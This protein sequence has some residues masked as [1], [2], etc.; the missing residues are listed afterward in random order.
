MASYL[1]GES[2]FGTSARTYP[3]NEVRANRFRY[4]PAALASR[5][6]EM[7]ISLAINIT[8]SIRLAIYSD[9]VTQP[10]A[11]LGV[12]NE[13]VNPTAGV[14]TVSMTAP[15]D[16]VPGSYY[17]LCVN[18][19]SAI[20]SGIYGTTSTGTGL[21][22]TITYA[23]GYPDPWGAAGT[24]LTTQTAIAGWGDTVN[25]YPLNLNPVNPV[26][27]SS[28]DLT[29][30]PSY[31][32]DVDTQSLFVKFEVY[33]TGADLAYPSLE[34]LTAADQL[35]K[36]HPFSPEAPGALNLHRFIG[37]RLPTGTRKIR[38]RT[39]G[40]GNPVW[41]NIAASILLP[42]ETLGGEVK[43]GTFLTR[44]KLLRSAAHD[45]NATRL[46]KNTMK[47]GRSY[48]TIQVIEVDSGGESHFNNGFN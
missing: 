3:A 20:T 29:F 35:L 23:T 2:V 44:A 30:A 21:Y 17:W 15:V 14:K 46:L 36:S 42:T 28:Q 45:T 39:N 48:F 11:R 43:S 12:S 10:N 16:L 37:C 4:S 34:L 9:G 19:S 8:G 38:I 18:V 1:L 6:T 32:T 24:S 26:G 33:Q 31:N 47:R 41:S 7:R 40:S 27:I 25:A 22:K 13:L 5:L